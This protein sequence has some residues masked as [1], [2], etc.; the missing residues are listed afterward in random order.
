MD[1]II[2]AKS[3]GRHHVAAA[4]AKHL[5]NLGL[6]APRAK[7]MANNY[8][9]S[10]YD[11]ILAAWPV[12]LYH[13][14]PEIFMS[15][16]SEEFNQLVAIHGNPFDPMLPRKENTVTTLDGGLTVIF[17]AES[18]RPLYWTTPDNKRGDFPA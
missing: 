9:E 4:L 14:E 16:S 2:V 17:N 10:H 18:G 3:G 12:P 5:P 11:E 13:L 6:R 8:W 15:Y 1:L 7:L